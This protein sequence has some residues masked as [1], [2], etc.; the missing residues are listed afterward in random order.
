MVA[1]PVVLYAP[2]LTAFALASA[3]SGRAPF[4]AGGWW[5][6]PLALAVHLVV[7]GRATPRWPEPARKAAHLLGVLVLAI[8]GALE[9]R[10]ITSGWGDY[11]T[12]WSWLGWL[13]VPAGLLLMLPRPAAA[14]VWPVSTAVRT[15]QTGA[16]GVLTFCALA[17]VLVANL[18]SDGTAVPLPYV[19]LVNP[20]DLGVA[21]AL[22][23]AW[24][25]RESEGGRTAPEQ[26]SRVVFLALAGNAFVWLNAILIRAFHHVLG[27]PFNFDAWTASLA[28][29]TGISLLWT[30]TALVLMWGAARRAIRAPWM[31]GAALL[32]AVVLKLIAVDLSGSGTVTRI[33]SFIGVGVLMLV[34]GYVAPLPGR[35]NA[36]V[37]R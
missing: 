17:W 34:I 15:Y 3:G 7:L 12:A 2:L 21:I 18:V 25:W 31:A 23:A 19:P 13:A 20:L 36:D 10:D 35:E 26:V 27:V 37:A 5:A 33:I 6:W 16:A 29:Q 8:L 22:F 24:R 4:E 28:V 14:R 1:M 9:G 32:G 30:A 11:R